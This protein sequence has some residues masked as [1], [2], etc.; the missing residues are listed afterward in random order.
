M[1][2]SGWDAALADAKQFI[3][4]CRDTIP[5]EQGMW[6][7]QAEREVGLGEVIAWIA[8]QAEQGHPGAAMGEPDRIKEHEEGR[9]RWAQTEIISHWQLRRE[10]SARVRLN[11]PISKTYQNFLS[12][13]M[14]G[15]ILPPNSPNNR[16]EKA[17]F[18][19]NR[20]LYLTV[21]HICECFGLTPYRNDTSPKLSGCDLVAQA[22]REVRGERMSYSTVRDAYRQKPGASTDSALMEALRI[23]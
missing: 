15:D 13:V 20:V 16:P 19:R 18:A 12:G 2:A 8:E 9:V 11:V 4:D 7:W 23:G 22:W 3:A 14:S 17:M 10:L 5:P 21:K 1:A 6:A